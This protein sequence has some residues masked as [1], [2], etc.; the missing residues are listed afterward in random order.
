MMRTR[1]KDM[2]ASP[3]SNQKIP[4]K[5]AILRNPK[6]PPP[7]QDLRQVEAIVSK[8]SLKVRRQRIALLFQR[9]L[10]SRKLLIVF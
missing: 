8:R 4:L 1:K 5:K 10:I 3:S 9:S 7:S 6:V 2:R